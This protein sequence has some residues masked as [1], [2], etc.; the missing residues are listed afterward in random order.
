MDPVLWLSG[1]SPFD[2]LGPV[3]SLVARGSGFE[4]SFGDGC[5]S[6]RSCAGNPRATE[7][8]RLASEAGWA[9]P[10]VAG[11]EHA[12]VVK[13]IANAHPPRTVA[14]TRAAEA[15]LESVHGSGVVFP[16]RSDAAA[17]LEAALARYLSRGGKLS[18]P[19]QW[20]VL[21]AEV[22][23]LAESADR[24]PLHGD[25]HPENFLV[26]GP[27]LYLLDWEYAGGGDP[28]WDWG[29]WSAASG[30]GARNERARKYQAIAK[31][32]WKLWEG[33]KG[34][35]DISPAPL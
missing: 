14:E 21:L 16:G 8:A 35:G 17:A 5:F 4:V 33:E 28:D 32:V 15:L 10:F 12:F 34:A 13:W 31:V 19:D 24:C 7:N 2:R 30:R 18:Q 22:R 3:T 1:R 27:A 25:P 20:S 26:A 11:D 29:Y 6:F 9:P 23:A